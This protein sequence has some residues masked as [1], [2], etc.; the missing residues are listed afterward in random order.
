MWGCKRQTGGIST[1]HRARHA[2][3]KM[4]KHTNPASA[5]EPCSE[6][7][8]LTEM[9]GGQPGQ[10]ARHARLD[11]GSPE[12]SGSPREDELLRG[13]ECGSGDVPP[14]IYPT[15]VADPNK[16]VSSFITLLPKGCKLLIS[17]GF[18]ES[19]DVKRETSVGFTNGIGVAIHGMAL[20]SSKI[21][22]RRPLCPQWLKI[23]TVASHHLL[24]RLFQ[25]ATICSVGVWRG[26]RFQRICASSNGNSLLRRHVKTTWRRVAGRTASHVPAAGTG[27]RIGCRNIDGGNG[28]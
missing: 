21:D 2:E 20:H 25:Q 5:L 9:R 1:K 6:P 26:L 24:I 16:R 14:E 15:I 12:I 11:R 8:R 10:R 18:N 23:A 27:G 28:G 17:N 22:A 3:S 13:F 4:G 7:A 19:G